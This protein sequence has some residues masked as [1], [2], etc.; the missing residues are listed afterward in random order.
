[1]HYQNLKS[2]RSTSPCSLKSSQ[3]KQTRDANSYPRSLDARWLAGWLAG[4]LTATVNAIALA[5]MAQK[6]EP[7]DPSRRTAMGPGIFQPFNLKSLEALALVRE[8]PSRPVREIRG[9]DLCS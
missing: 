2:R 6:L 1:M 3:V 9:L 7:E 8:V 4:Y 5:E